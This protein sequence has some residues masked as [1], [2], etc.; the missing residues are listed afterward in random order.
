MIT[1]KDR[2]PT[3]TQVEVSSSVNLL[4]PWVHEELRVRRWRQRFALGLLALVVVIAGAWSY[5]RVVLAQVEADLRGEEATAESL[6]GRI[7][8]LGSR[9]AS[10]SATSW[11]HSWSRNT[12]TA[13]ADSA[14][15]AWRSA[16]EALIAAI[17]ARSAVAMSKDS[18]RR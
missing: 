3:D 5:E 7:A 14:M 18:A 10:S 9:P 16:R 13:S 8:D 11:G 12:L 17:A 2:S 6:Q 4:S 1:L 15:T